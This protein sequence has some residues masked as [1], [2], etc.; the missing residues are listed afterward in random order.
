MTL[1]RDGN[2]PQ[3]NEDQK[4]RDFHGLSNS[5]DIKIWSLRK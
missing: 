3:K 4:E 1:K 2:G 5:K